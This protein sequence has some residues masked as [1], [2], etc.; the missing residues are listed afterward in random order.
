MDLYIIIYV[1]FYVG[2]LVV[3]ESRWNIYSNNVGLIIGQKESPS[4][5]VL[6]L[7]N[8]NLKYHLS[9]ALIPITLETI[10]KIKERNCTIK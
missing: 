1:I 3:L 4:D 2:Q 6:V 8:T 9:D 7:W 10:N 5:L